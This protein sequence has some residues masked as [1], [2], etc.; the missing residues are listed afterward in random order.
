MHAKK[1]RSTSTLKLMQSVDRSA[2]TCKIVALLP[3]VM[4]GCTPLEIP[5][6]CVVRAVECVYDKEPMPIDE[7]V[8]TMFLGGSSP[9]WLNDKA[10]VLV[11]SALS[12]PPFASWTPQ[13]NF[14][15][16]ETH[17]SK[18]RT[19][20]KRKKYVQHI[21]RN[22]FLPHVQ[23][24]EQRLVYL[25]IMVRKI[26]GVELGYIP[27]DDRDHNANKR[28]DGPGPLL[29]ILFR[30]LFRNHLKQIK[31]SLT[32]AVEANKHINVTDFMQPRRIEVGLG[33]HFATGTWSLNRNTNNG[34]VQVMNRMSQCSMIS[35]LRRISIPLSREGKAP[36]VRQLH[37][38]D[39]RLFCPSEVRWYFRKWVSWVDCVPGCPANVRIAN[40]VPG[41]PANVRIMQMCERRPKAQGLD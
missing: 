15:W 40:C 30:Q 9:D 4:R 19:Q 34:V 12:T 7:L 14:D 39:W 16:I 29:A 24:P 21:L 20:V 31:Q 25:G 41:C 5:I 1:W 37:P 11:T 13:E 17:G 18:E 23:D 26:V 10:R 8:R 35:H 6:I 3:F 36:L 32:R 38:T 27:V 22:E 28:L 2:E 33:Y